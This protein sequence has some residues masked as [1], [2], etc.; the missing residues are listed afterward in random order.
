MDGPNQNET[1]AASLEDLKEDLI[2][3]VRIG[4]LKRGEATT[5][6]WLTLLAASDLRLLRASVEDSL[7]TV[8][9][10]RLKVPDLLGILLLLYAMEQG[11][12]DVFRIDITEAHQ[13]VFALLFLIDFELL[14]R[15][16]LLRIES[17]GRIS[18]EEYTL[19]AYRLECTPQV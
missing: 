12:G 16:G 6:E 13:R 9:G 10:P 15:S 18:A 7:F 17:P 14:S 19:V 1:A 3:L 2:R 11:E 4:R 5:S 8:Q